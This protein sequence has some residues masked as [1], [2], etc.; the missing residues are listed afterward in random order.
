MSTLTNTKSDAAL[1][2]PAMTGKPLARLPLR[3][4]HRAI[5]TRDQE[6]TRHFMEDILG[7]P[8]VATWCESIF[9]PEVGHDV[10]FCHT[11]FA[12][13]DDS[14]IAFFQFGDPVIQ[15]KCYRRDF[16]EIPRFDHI[17]IK[18]TRATQNEII[19]RLKA[20]GV[21]YRSR[22]MVIA[23]P[24]MSRSPTAFILNLPTIRRIS[25]KSARSGRPMRIPNWHDG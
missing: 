15:E 8:L 16:P 13:E 21:P 9:M 10:S 18:S 7:I 20:A 17:A 2:A 23:N 25:R 22:I 5:V 24:S 3:M 1:A 11:F 14:C 6:S 4:H 12:L 19:G